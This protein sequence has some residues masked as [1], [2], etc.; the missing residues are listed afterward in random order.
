MTNSERARREFT[1]TWTLDGP[2]AEVFRAWTDP[3]HLEWFYNAEYPVPTEPIEL[4][5][6]VGGVCP[7]RSS[8][9]PGEQPAAGRSST[10]PGSTTARSS[11]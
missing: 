1:L 10:P 3:D 9:S 8:C 7:T 4:D 2:P 6:R 5:L 11:P